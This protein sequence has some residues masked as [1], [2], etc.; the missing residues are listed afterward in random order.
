MSLIRIRTQK[1]VADLTASASTVVR[2]R[3]I[4]AS[5]CPFAFFLLF[6]SKQTLA[7]LSDP[8]ISGVK[9]DAN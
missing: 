6:D 1:I 5:E 8:E 7:I 4:G 3:G 2:T 9:Q